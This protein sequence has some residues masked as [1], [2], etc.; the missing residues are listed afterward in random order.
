MW[1]DPIVDQVRKVRQEHARKYG[2]DLRAIYDALKQQEETGHHER[3]SFAPKRIP[4]EDIA[5]DLAA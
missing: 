5:Q 1:Q 4:R 2:F 3:A